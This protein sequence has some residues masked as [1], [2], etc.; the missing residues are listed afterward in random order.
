MSYYP[1]QEEQEY[2]FYAD[3]TTAVPMMTASAPMLGTVDSKMATTAPMTTAAPM[4]GSSMTGSS[5]KSYKK[6]KSSGRNTLLTIVVLLLLG[7]LAWYLYNHSEEASAAN[8]VK[9]QRF[10]FRR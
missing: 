6:H 4:M 8:P 9:F 3:P 5:M 7:C 2:E 10:R 1:E